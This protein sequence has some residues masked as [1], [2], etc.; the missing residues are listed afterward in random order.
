M[1]AWTREGT[2]GRVTRFNPG[3]GSP[4]VILAPVAVPGPRCRPVWYV[5]AGGDGRG[6]PGR[7]RC[8]RVATTRARYYTLGTPS[9]CTA[10]PC[11]DHLLH[12]TT[13][14]GPPGPLRDT[15]AT[16]ARSVTPGLPWSATLPR[17]PPA[18]GPLPCPEWYSWSRGQRSPG[19]SGSADRGIQGYP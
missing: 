17:V 7:T 18:P 9:S 8:T 3:P 5:G 13:V 10:P 14:S 15:R 16:L 1:T 19:Y 2:Q 11:Q 12:R 6:V 4:M